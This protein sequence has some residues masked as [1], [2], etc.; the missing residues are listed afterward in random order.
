MA[1]EGIMPVRLIEE[2][3][4]LK[5]WLIS[6]VLHVTVAPHGCAAAS[7]FGKGSRFP[8]TSAV[9]ET[10]NAGFFE[11]GT[12]AFL[13]EGPVDSMVL[14][15]AGGENWPWVWLIDELFSPGV[16]ALLLLVWLIDELLFVLPR[17]TSCSPA[18]LP[19]LPAPCCEVTLLLSVQP[20]A[21]LCNS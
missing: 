17:G 10:R 9:F 12:T 3:C 16:P 19:A 21:Q 13:W 18:A 5:Y 6:E 1:L 2:Q 8:W 20:F 11:A 7:V 4:T 14:S 15:K